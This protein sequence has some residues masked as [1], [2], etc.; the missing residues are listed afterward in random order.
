MSLYNFTSHKQCE[1]LTN[2]ILQEKMRCASTLN[3][4]P[5]LLFHSEFGSLDLIQ[6]FIDQISQSHGKFN[7]LAS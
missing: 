2:N 3:S 5:V 6:T 7:I 4:P 1:D